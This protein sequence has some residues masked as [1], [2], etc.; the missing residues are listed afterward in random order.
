MD[1]WTWM[2]MRLYAPA[3]ATAVV[4]ALA[5]IMLSGLA[6]GPFGLSFQPVLRWGTLAGAIVTLGLL[7]IASFRLWRWTDGQGRLCDCGGVLGR[8]RPGIRGRTDYRRCLACDRA[9][10]S[11]YYE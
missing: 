10:S 7:A 4:T 1:R 9:V 6:V 5:R 2:A 3:A 8:E 11:R